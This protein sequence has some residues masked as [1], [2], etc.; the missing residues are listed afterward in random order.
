MTSF[1]VFGGVVH[2]VSL[3]GKNI[4]L[5]IKG[6][7]SLTIPQAAQAA[8]CS[9]KT[10]KK[11]LDFYASVGWVDC[12]IQQYRPNIKSRVYVTAVN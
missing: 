9:W 6:H 5:L 8:K 1:I 10:A 12:Y 4:G 11:W 2:Q 7:E 3:P